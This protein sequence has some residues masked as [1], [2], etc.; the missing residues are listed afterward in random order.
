MAREIM[1]R[2]GDKVRENNRIGKVISIHSAGTVDVLFDDKEYPI[3][4]QVQSL[5]KVNPYF[6][7]ENRKKKPLITVPDFDLSQLQYKAQI[8]GI[9]KALVKKELGLPQRTDFGK[10]RKRLDMLLPQELRRLLLSKAFAIATSVGRKHGYLTKKRGK[11][12]TPIE[13]TE[14]GMQRMFER[15]QDRKHVKETIED[16]E[17]TLKLARKK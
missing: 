7:R 6:F 5:Y 12:P 1:F 2:V 16:Y 11:Q 4:R 3:R 8:N 10:K 17:L 13:T 15:L 14:L 9:Y